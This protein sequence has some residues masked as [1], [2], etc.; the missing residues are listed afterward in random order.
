MGEWASIVEHIT[1]ILLTGM[2]VPDTPMERAAV[3]QPGTMARAA[4]QVGAEAPPRGIMDR[5]APAVSVAARPRGVEALEARPDGEAARS[6][7]VAVADSGDDALLGNSE[8]F[9]PRVRL[10]S[11][12]WRAAML[13]P[14]TGSRTGLR[15]ATINPEVVIHFGPRSCQR[16]I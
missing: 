15:S 6:P 14:G 11:V 13:D 16:R 7:G 12:R 9:A 5:E 3:R 8:G 2:V 4:P 10:Q 1:A